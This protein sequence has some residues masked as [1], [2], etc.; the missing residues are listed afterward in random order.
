MTISSKM[1]MVFLDLE[2]VL[3]PEI[4]DGLAELTNIKEL[5]LNT[6]DISDYDELMKHRLKICNQNNLTLKDIHKVVGNIEPFDGALEFLTSI[7]GK[8]CAPH[9]LPINI[10]SHWE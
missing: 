4:W 10:E 1:L 2:G 8:V 6:K 7:Y 3:I 5:R 9:S